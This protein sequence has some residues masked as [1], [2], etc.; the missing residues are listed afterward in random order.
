[1]PG[2][3]KVHLPRR[4]DMNQ[5]LFSVLS[6]TAIPGSVETSASVPG[7]APSA[8]DRPVTQIAARR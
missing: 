8:F 2:E 3:L 1:M 7:V 4:D 5:P 6:L